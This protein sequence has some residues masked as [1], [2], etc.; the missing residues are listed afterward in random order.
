MVSLVVGLIAAAV[1]LILSGVVGKFAENRG[2]S[3][4]LWYVFSLLCSPIVGFAVV[5]LLPSAAVVSRGVEQ[6][7]SCRA[8]I[9]IEGDTCPVCHREL[10]RKVKEKLAA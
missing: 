6:C 7:P 9:K 8:M 5:A 3:G 10:V 4:T 2:H 1:W